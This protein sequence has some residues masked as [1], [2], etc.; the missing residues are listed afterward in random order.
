MDDKVLHTVVPYDPSYLEKEELEGITIWDADVNGTAPF[1]E[2][3]IHLIMLD[4]DVSP[5]DI[6]F[7]HFRVT[8][9]DKI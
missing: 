8:E 2:G 6:Y 7:K 5:D 9:K 3:Q 1:I 4:N